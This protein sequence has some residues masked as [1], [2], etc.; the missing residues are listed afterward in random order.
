MPGFRLTASWLTVKLPKSS[1]KLSR[2]I[3][4]R[5]DRVARL[6]QREHRKLN[7][8]S[9]SLRSWFTFS[10]KTLLVSNKYP[11]NNDKLLILALVSFLLCIGGT[12]SNTAKYRANFLHFLH[13]EM[14]LSQAGICGG[15]KAAIELAVQR[16]I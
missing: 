13:A 3:S 2:E 15:M 16:K 6:M 4:S 10:D 1:E 5:K 12:L 7:R 14:I 9:F 8:K 11:I